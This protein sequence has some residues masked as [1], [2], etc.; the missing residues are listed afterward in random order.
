MVVWLLASVESERIGVIV[1][2]TYVV[3]LGGFTHV[4]VGSIDVL[5]AVMRGAWGWGAFLEGYFLPALIGN[6]LGGVSLVSALNHAQV[7]AGRST[8]S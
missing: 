3:G 5:V 1:I 7:V 4:I 2:L 8:R 6:V